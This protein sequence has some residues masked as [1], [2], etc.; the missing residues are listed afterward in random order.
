MI[1]QI[2]DWFKKAVPN[3]TEQTLNTQLGVHFEECGEF[4]ESIKGKDF[5]TDN[6][7]NDAE[8][9]MKRLATCLKSRMGEVVIADRQEFLDAVCDQ[10]VT[11]TGCG[12]MA[13]MQTVAAMEEVNRSNF[14]KFKPDGTPIFDENGKIAKNK[15]TY[16]KA[17]LS[18][19]Y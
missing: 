16:R 13:G 12:Y 15:E 2:S 10:I 4:L 14:S 3:P 8:L 19:M 11:A 7:V 9:A 6:L 1:A 5:V 18:G 17:D